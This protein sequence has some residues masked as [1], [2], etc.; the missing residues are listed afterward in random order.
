MKIEYSQHLVNRLAL[1][2]IDYELPLKLYHESNEHYHDIETGHIIAIK[3]VLIYGK[4]R[5]VMIAYDTGEQSVRILTI[6]PLKEG[7]KANRTQSGR[8]RRI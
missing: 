3:E 1:R 2:K 7:Q 4:P 5:E 6:H 8:W